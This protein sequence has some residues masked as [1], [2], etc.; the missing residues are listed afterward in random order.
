MLF[1]E[2]CTIIVKGGPHIAFFLLIGVLAIVLKVCEFG[3]FGESTNSERSENQGNENDEG[4]LARS[5]MS[6]PIVARSPSPFTARGQTA[7]STS[8]PADGNLLRSSASS[9]A[10]PQAVE[11][12]FLF[13]KK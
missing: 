11:V 1:S 3:C 6:L 8:S 12:G 9:P 10:A 4:P 2:D 13:D 5:Q 7:S